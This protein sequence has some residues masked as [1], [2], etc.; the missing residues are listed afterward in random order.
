[1]FHFDDLN[2]EICCYPD[3]PFWPSG[4]GMSTRGCLKTRRHGLY[5]LWKLRW[6]RDHCR[7]ADAEVNGTGGR[8]R[9]RNSADLQKG[10]A[11]AYLRGEK[12]SSTYP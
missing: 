2:Y 4:E 1:M 10:S 6:S 11:L 3:F 8:W 5:P 7:R 12:L 9:V